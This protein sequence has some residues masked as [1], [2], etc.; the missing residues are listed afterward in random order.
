MHKIQAQSERLEMTVNSSRILTL[1]Q[2]I[3]QAQVNNPE[4]LELT[5]LSPNQIQI[6]AKKP[7]VTQI[8]LWGENKQIYTVDVAIVPDARELAAILQANFPKTILKVVPVGSKVIDL[9]LR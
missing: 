4:F 8:N 9:R 3:P 2:K 1:D 6:A 7:G 5:P